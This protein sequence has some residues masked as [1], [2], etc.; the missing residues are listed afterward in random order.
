MTRPRFIQGDPRRTRM[1]VLKLGDFW[2]VFELVQLDVGSRSSVHPDTT[3]E[4]WSAALEWAYRSASRDRWY[5][6]QFGPDRWRW[7]SVAKRRKANAS[8]PTVRNPFTELS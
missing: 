8:D 4:T 2:R 3:F 6:E 1:R 7:P 5:A